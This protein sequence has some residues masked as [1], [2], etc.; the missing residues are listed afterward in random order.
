MKAC[1]SKEGKHT[2]PTSS[3]SSK[4]S[5]IVQAKLEATQPNDTYEQEAD[6]MTQ[7]VTQMPEQNFVQR[8]CAECERE[9][10]E[11][12]QRKTAANVSSVS[13]SSNVTVS[14]A[15]SNSINSLQG[16]GTSL[17][18]NTQSFMSNRFG[19][20]FSNVKI[21]T[22]NQAAQLN[23]DLNAK[24]FTVGNDI[25][26]NEGQYQPNS[27]SGKQLLAH[28]LTHTLQQTKGIKR[29]IIQRACH[30][31]SN[32][33]RNITACAEGAHDVGRQAQGQP[34]TI[35]ARAEA[36]INTA[37]GPGSNQDK[38]MQ[39]VND[40]ICTYMPS[41]VS[42]VRKL[43]YFAGES[44]LHTQSVGSGSG[45]Q[46]DICVGDTFLNGTTRSGIARRVLQVAHEL[47]HI[48]QYRTG[49]AG[50]TNKRLREFLAF[51]HEAL[52]DE[53][54]GTRRMPDAMRRTL[55]DAALGNYNCLSDSLKAT[56]QSKQQEL[57]TR[58]QAVNGTSG[59]ASTNPPAACV[60]TA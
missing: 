14:D 59:N 20:D 52:A 23:K 35:D 48:E 12:L 34:N 22:D 15:V 8:K 42:K 17:D 10:K 49:L 60:P 26:F 50:G 4:P 36:I 31:G 40:I 1:I 9:D 51:Y 11:K 44:G 2:S 38:A 57:L 28:E 47:E 54:I 5:F 33:E 41:Q 55:I 25:Y 19:I 30:E 53:F 32:P 37:Q 18:A 16:K 45:A 29:K 43:S 21:H 58:R 13:N 6:S 7:Q 56:H 39:V 27:S 24:A 3:S 46:G